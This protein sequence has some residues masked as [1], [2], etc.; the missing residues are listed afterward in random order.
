MGKVC[1][2]V[3]FIDQ[4]VCSLMSNSTFTMGYLL[5]PWVLPVVSLILATSYLV[6]MSFPVG[7]T[8]AVCC[9]LCVYLVQ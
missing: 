8:C 4:A 1:T 5:S 7:C 3:L 9:S 2:S 6:Y